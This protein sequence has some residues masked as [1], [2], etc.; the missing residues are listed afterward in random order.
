MKLELTEG[1]ICDSFEVDGNPIKDCDESQLKHLL[2]L[3][4]Q[5]ICCKEFTPDQR[6]LAAHILR[7]MVEDFSDT[8]KCSDE[9]C[10]FCGDYVETYTMEV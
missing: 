9:P 7:E 3:A 2:I 10:E 5:K 1:C 8:Y 4:T 6:G